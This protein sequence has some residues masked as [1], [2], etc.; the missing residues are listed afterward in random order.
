M[1]IETIWAY[2]TENELG[3]EGLCGFQDPNT[4]QWLPMVAADE[5]RLRLL[6]PFAHQIAVITKRKV[7][8]VKFYNR[9][10]CEEICDKE[11]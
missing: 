1:R 5:T 4:Q 3:D 9:E 10:D 6:K 2:I 7:K 11:S 8:L